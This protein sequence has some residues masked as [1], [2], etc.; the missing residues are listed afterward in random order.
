MHTADRTVRPCHTRYRAPVCELDLNTEQGFDMTTSSYYHENCSSI[1][2][3]CFF[4]LS[5]FFFGHC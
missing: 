3:Y 2:F 4:L 1:V 5:Y